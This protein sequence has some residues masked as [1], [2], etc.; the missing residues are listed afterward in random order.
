MADR[1]HRTNP[2]EIRAPD[3]APAENATHVIGEGVGGDAEDAAHG[4]RCGADA[5]DARHPRAARTRAGADDIVREPEVG[6]EPFD[7]AAAR[8]EALG[9]Q[10]ERQPRDTRRADGAA[11]RVRG[12]DERDA[13]AELRDLAGRDEATDPR[14]DHDDASILGPFVQVGEV[15]GLVAHSACTSST[16]RVSTV[17]SVSGGTP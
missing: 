10:I 14:T 15:V 8:G 9:S 12:V 13:D 7:M 11:R 1:E 3:T 17:G 16:M 4:K 2:I 6:Q 5:R